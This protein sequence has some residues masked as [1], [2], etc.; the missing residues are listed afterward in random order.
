MPDVESESGALESALDTFVIT[1]ASA[2]LVEAAG[3]KQ[4]AFLIAPVSF[5]TLSVKRF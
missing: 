5:E 3:R 2:A 1:K 4:R